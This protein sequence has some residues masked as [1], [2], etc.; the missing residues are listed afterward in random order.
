MDKLVVLKIGEG[1]FEQGFPVTLQ[2][3]QEGHRPS[4]EMVAAVP[5]AP[6]LPQSYQ[7]WQSAYLSLG[8]TTRLDA[9]AQQVTNIA[10]QE[11]YAA[12]EQTAQVLQHSLNQWLLA[13]AFRPIRDKWLEQLLP[14]D[15]IRVLLQTDDLQLQRLPWHQWELLQRYPDA[16]IALSAPIYE[17]SRYQSPSKSKVNVLA[18]LGSSQGIDTQADR[19]ILEQLP[20]AH[21]QLLV[22]P[23]RHTLTDQLWEQHWDILFFAGHSHSRDSCHTGQ[24][25]LNGQEALTIHQLKYALQAA[26]RRGLKLAIFNSCDGLGLA[27]PL[28]DLQIPAI[29]LMREPVPDEVAQSFLKHFLKSFSQGQLFHLAVKEARQRLED[30]EPRF[31][32][33]T[34]LPIIYQNPAETPPTWQGLRQGA[35]QPLW[36]PYSP[37]VTPVETVLEDQ[38]YYPQPQV[39]ALPHTQVSLRSRIRDFCHQRWLSL[40]PTSL[41]VATILLGIRGLGGLQPLELWAFDR[42]LRLRPVE[43]PDPRLLI[44]LVTDKD[45]QAQGEQVRRSSLSD[46]AL[47]RVLTKLEQAEPRAIG[48]DIYRDFAVNLPQ[49]DLARRLRTSKRLVVPCKG[50]DQGSDPA[51]IAPPPEV[52]DAN[53]IGF[54]D[55]VEDEDG[56]LRR[57]LLYMSQG[58]TSPCAASFSFASLLAFHY[59]EDKA[60][61]LEIDLSESGKDRTFALHLQTPKRTAASTTNQQ[62]TFRQ[63]QPQQGGYQGGDPK[64]MAGLQIMLNYRALNQLTDIAETVSVQQLLAGQ[65]HRKAIHNKVVLIGVQASG[66][67]DYWTTPYGAGPT[68]KIAG[69]FMQAHMLSQIISTVEDQRPSLWMWPLWADILW[70][71]GWALVGGGLALVLR[72]TARLGVV[73]IVVMSLLGSICLAGLIQGAWI[74]LIP[75]FLAFVITTLGILLVRTQA[76]DRDHRLQGT[77]STASKS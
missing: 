11:L 57:Q 21:V 14:S 50:S 18:I 2:I 28:A 6:E 74:P 49:T 71:W 47:N 59:L 24:I 22:E 12:C 37:L 9:P 55:F 69:V 66:S 61:Q 43:G 30:L 13:E 4:I 63:I 68:Q 27:H 15:C 48:L 72:L 20:Q 60:G 23:N 56:I 54:T 38:D 17:G 41:I 10:W 45:I 35:E 58:S 36:H 3:G 8:L 67:G 25:W 62:I 29:V 65:V 46:P 51:G 31:P 1:N 64:S 52:S 7:A 75:A 33:A 5:Q 53:R 42:L 26:I 76:F 70:V 16:E 34:W 73:S 39:P 19:T 77:L 40:F 32:C 44:V